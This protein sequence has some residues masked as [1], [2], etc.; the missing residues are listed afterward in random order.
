MGKA[1]QYRDKTKEEL[2]KQLEDFK[3]ELAQL[4]VSKVSGQG[5][6]SKLAKIKVIRK[7][8]ARVL[9]VFNSQ[10]RDA[11]RKA[12]R[13]KEY[14]PLQ[15]RLKRTRAL[16]RALTKK[17][18]TLILMQRLIKIDEQV[19]TDP[20]FPAGFMDV[21]KIDRTNEVFRLLYDTKGRFTLHK[22][23]AEEAKFKLCRVRKVALGPKGVPFIVTHDG[24][25]IRYPHPDVK[26]NDVVK[27]D[28]ATGTFKD[29]TKFE[30]GNLAVTTGGRNTGRVGIIVSR[31]KHDGAQDVIYMKD[32]V[33]H[34]WS[35]LIGNTFVLGKGNTSQVTL[36]KDKGIK[37]S[38]SEDRERKLRKLQQ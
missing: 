14:K 8:I 12:Y 28:L 38:I 9:T 4:R 3:N 1:Y 5:G 15:I 29:F 6:P 26:V 25:T 31:E 21:I 19:R 32:S 23:D 13:K 33:G 16:R 24:R 35:T 20:G 27:V 34:T 11:V 17:E 22:I 37:L 7:S 2:Q 36:P 30:T 18:V 10:S